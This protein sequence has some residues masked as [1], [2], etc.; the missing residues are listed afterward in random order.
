M[1]DAAMAFDFSTEHLDHEFPVRKHGVYFNHAAVAPLPRRV[2]DAIDAH[3]H[4]VRDRG[5]ANWRT[6]YG[7][8]EAAREAAAAFIGGDP[9]GVAFLPSTSWGLNLVARAYPWTPGDN[10]VG[11]DMEFPANVYPWMLL[12]NRGVEYRRA[13]SRDGRVTLADLEAVVDHRTRVLSVSWVAFHNGWVYPI[14]EIGRFCRDRGILFVLDA[15]QG[16][17]ALP[18]DLSSSP[19]DVLVADAHKWLLGPEACAIFHVAESARDRVAPPFGGWWNVRAPGSYLDHRLDFFSGG[20]R[21]EAGTLPTGQ[22]FGLAA[23]LALL[24]EIGAETV[25]ARILQTNAALAEGLAAL[26]WTIASPPPQASGILAA[27]P[28]FGTA[29]AAAKRFESAGI[30]VSPREGAVRFS[31]HVYNDAREVVRILE[32]AEGGGKPDAI[33]PPPPPVP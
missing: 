3:T 29:A 27:V 16:L 31:P 9:A 2:A 7:R 28:P 17:G 18:I 14:D 23:A 32:C 25:R 4:D 11:D 6:W 33:A 19:V 5:A 8:I 13:R 26:G 24:E 15:I 1:L 22:I 10:V 21:Y 30:L 12:E 20:R